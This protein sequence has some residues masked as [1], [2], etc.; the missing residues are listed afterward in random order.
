MIIARGLHKSFGPV[1]AVRD[2][3]FAI[4]GPGV[5][6]LLGPNGAGKS[7][8]IRM[9]TGLIHP[10]FGSAFI[11][12]HDL[13]DAPL[14]AR[15]ALGYAPETAPLYPEL[16]P[17]EYL[18]HRARLHYMPRAARRVA[19]DREID[20]CQLRSVSTRRIAGLSKGYRQRVALAAALVHDPAVVVLDEPAS[21]LDPAQI[22]ELRSLIRSLGETKAVLLSSHILP[23]I[24]RT[25]D[26]VLII[27][28]GRLLADGSPDALTRAPSVDARA[29]GVVAEV[30][31]PGGAEGDGAQTLRGIAERLAAQHAC[32]FTLEPVDGKWL[33]LRLSGAD[34][35]PDHTQDPNPDL[36]G[37]V[38]RALVE[39]GARVR[40][41][42][43][44]PERAK[45][46]TLEE[47]FVTLLEDAARDASGGGTR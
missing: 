20:R 41:L 18:R 39:S 19:I 30:A 36:V 35:S 6:G 26:R 10:D 34:P 2:L 13:A 42:D 5:T 38:L 14:E 24:E 47:R 11:A 40:Y 7:T 32:A 29:G 1:D 45:S 4:E 46:V 31:P 17:T 3:S 9:L 21:G 16:T 22:I 25:C 15:R 33:R 8:T 12:G 27:A 23:E 44:R 28:A 43:A 37:P